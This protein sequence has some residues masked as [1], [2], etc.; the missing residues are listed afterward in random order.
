MGH[1]QHVDV[2]ENKLLVYHCPRCR[3]IWKRAPKKSN[4]VEYLGKYDA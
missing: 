3:H 1:K 2:N 4:V